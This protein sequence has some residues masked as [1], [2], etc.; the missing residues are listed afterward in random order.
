MSIAAVVLLLFASVPP[1][2]EAPVFGA[3]VGAMSL[4]VNAF[5]D[6]GRPVPDLRPEEFVVRVDREPRRVISARFRSYAPGSAVS[7]PPEGEWPTFSTNDGAGQGRIIFVLVDQEN[8]SLGSSRVMQSLAD[9]LLEGLGPRD[10]VSVLTLPG[11]QTR[12]RL[13]ADHA[14]LRPALVSISG[15]SRA[16]S[17]RLTLYEASAFVDNDVFAWRETL[18]RECPR[19]A[20]ATSTAVSRSCAES[21]ETEARGLVQGFRS[22][23]SA[24]V[25]GLRSLM[26]SLK[27]TPGR[28]AL[29]LVTEGFG[30]QGSDLKSLAE[31]AVAARAML[32]VVLLEDSAGDSSVRRL[33]RNS[34]AERQLRTAAA[35]R[36]ASL[37]G[38]GGLVRAI[39]GGEAAFSRIAGELSGDYLVGFEP[40]A[41]D[42]DGKAHQVRVECTRRGVTLR[43]RSVEIFPAPARELRRTEDV[44]MAALEAHDTLADLPLKVATHSLSDRK[45]AKTRILVSAEIGRSGKAPRSVAVGFVVADETGGIVTSGFEPPTSGATGVEHPLPFRATVSV[46]AGRYLLKLAAVDEQ[47]RAGSVV[48]PLRAGL[49]YAGPLELSDFVLATHSSESTPLPDIDPRISDGR[50]VGYLELHAKDELDL[51]NARVSLEVSGR[52]ST[53]VL[54]ASPAA[55]RGSETG[56]SA[57]Q[58]SLDVGL[59]PPGEYVASAVVSISGQTLRRLSR[60]FQVAGGAGASG[61]ARNVGF[62]D[63]A[64]ALKPFARGDVL[65][66]D[67]LGG[68]LDRLERSASDGA[69]G[70]ARQ[71]IASGEI[72]SLAELQEGDALSLAFLRGLGLFARGDDRA[73]ADQF[74]AALRASSEFLPAVFYLG[75]CYAASGKDQ[76]AAGAWRTSLAGEG[77]FPASYRLIGEAMLRANQADEALEILQE[78]KEL[79]PADASF[80][81]PLGIAHAL[82]GNRD[83][84]L[85]ALGAHVESHRDD[86]GALFLATRLLFDRHVESP[87]LGRERD[88]L[89]RRARGYVAAGGPEQAV[90]ARWLKYV[91][92][93]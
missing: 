11:P 37:A 20:G 45:T 26:G 24:I 42:R 49:T 40:Q 41:G 92:G 4:D 47:G 32:H 19:T 57:R 46:P 74:R 56:W 27:K 12:L 90:V 53:A 61:V 9:R 77:A 48:H 54:L 36:L 84:A 65:G 44:V 21:L 67:S 16:S 52:D 22:E 68:A 63:V 58:G 38:G 34:S 51:V 69:A 18:A 31:E 66:A 43:A 89:L 73:A 13:T 59:L 71:R 7:R 78:G 85:E 60:P 87:L 79:W 5:D 25:S 91:E 76:E 50:L 93:Q 1:Q 83:E 2:S 30:E 55:E 8:L 10:Q 3:S 39:G 75:A 88:L 33:Q 70:V 81:R 23:A 62:D 72:P 15:R 6:D 29:I 64:S 86:L 14:R 17:F 28:K 80:A 35:E 82:A